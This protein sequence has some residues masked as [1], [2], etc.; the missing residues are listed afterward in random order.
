[1]INEHKWLDDDLRVIDST[2]DL[3]TIEMQANDSDNGFFYIEKED[4]ITIAKHFKL[5]AHDICCGEHKA[6]QEDANAIDEAHFYECAELRAEIALLNQKITI[7]K[8]G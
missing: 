6:L 4:A 3:N 2:S 1:M 5:T 8:V 7:N